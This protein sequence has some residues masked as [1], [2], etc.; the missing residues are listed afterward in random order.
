MAAR[1]TMSQAEQMA[2]LIKQKLPDIE[3][4][5][6]RIW[7]EW[8]GLPYDG[9]HAL[10]DCD[11][12]GDLLQMHFNEGEDLLVWSPCDLRI[13]PPRMRGVTRPIFSIREATRV[14]WEWFHYGRPKIA[15][16]RYF[17]EFVKTTT[18]IAATSN[19]DWYIPNL[20]PKPNEVA[21]EML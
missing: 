14:R 11:A 16:N 2:E 15:A 4:G 7:G 9:W 20:G 12:Q 19:V 10:V 3:P 6:P 5:S 17:I 18:A 1:S 21:V 13:Y 8:F